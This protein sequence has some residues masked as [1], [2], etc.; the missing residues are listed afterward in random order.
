MLEVG[1][2]AVMLMAL[3]TVADVE[4]CDLHSEVKNFSNF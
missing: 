2:R 1:R 4:I 3:A